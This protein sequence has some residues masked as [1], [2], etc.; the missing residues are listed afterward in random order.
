MLTPYLL[1]LWS[2]IKVHRWKTIIF[3]VGVLVVGSGAYAVFTPSK[4]EY[5]TEV[6][7][8]GDLVQTVEAVGTVISD[9]DLELQF[10]NIGII[11]QVL[12]KEGD[13]VKAG[14]KLA[15][16]RS[17][18]LAA[19][20][21]AAYARVKELEASLRALQEGTRPE[22]I[23]VAEA[24]LLNRIAALDIARTTLRNAD[25]SMETAQVKLD[26]LKQEASISLSGQMIQA[27]LIASQNITTTEQS[28]GSIETIF[29]RSN[30]QDILDRESK[31]SNLQNIRDESSRIDT[32]IN[33]IIQKTFSTA[34]YKQI[35][36]LLSEYKIIIERAYNN[37]SDAYNLL[38]SLPE[39]PYLSFSYTEKDAYRV[40]LAGNRTQIQAALSNVENWIKTFR[41]ATANF[42][43]RIANEES[44]FTSAKGTRERA[45]ADIT[46][47]E[48]SIRI[49]E[50]QLALKRAGNRKTDIDAAQARLRA[51]YAEVARANANLLDTVINAPSNGRIT[52]VN[53]KAGEATPSGAAITMLGESPYRIEIFASEIDIPKIKY[54]QAATIE[55]DAFPDVNYKL[56]VGEIDETQTIIDG[57][58]KYRV[59]LDFVFPHDEFKLGMTGD[60]V[61]NSDERKNI[62][63]IPSRSVL[64]DASRKYVRVLNNEVTIIEKNVE[65]GM[66]G[67]GGDMEI[68]KGLDEGEK[69]II[70]VK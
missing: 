6:S 11:A 38:V 23:K 54:S 62:I 18:D 52:K 7:R 33:N 69:V 68:I 58:A 1:P 46:N 28:L 48:T 31:N 36:N 3:T 64:E 53:I 5:I 44:A 60:T 16:L 67:E 14:Q 65:T 45:A 4:P 63:I 34:D 24:Q 42:D 26:A 50:A 70:L 43:T 17:G 9:R 20:V 47:Y 32:L 66:E 57:V 25:E 55:L 10:R 2:V 22:E 37:I 61:I 30:V 8:R 51:A 40:T 29:L 35:I 39:V 12:V 19:G 56:S 41:D 49:D 21:S 59:K 27:P 15:S 13:T